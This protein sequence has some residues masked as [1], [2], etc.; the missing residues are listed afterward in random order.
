MMSREEILKKIRADN[1]RIVALGVS[2]ERQERYYSELSID[3]RDPDQDEQAF[4]N[5]TDGLN[6]SAVDLAFVK[7][8]L[9][10]GDGR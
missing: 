9:K 7:D 8:V 2:T 3:R 4:G 5:A 10:S 6:L 1:H